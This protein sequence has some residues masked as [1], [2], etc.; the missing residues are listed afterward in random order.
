MILLTVPVGARAGDRYRPYAIG[1]GCGLCS[2]ST[3]TPGRWACGSSVRTSAGT[4]AVSSRGAARGDGP[5][6]SGRRL[7][8]FAASSDRGRSHP[9]SLRAGGDLALCCRGSG[10]RPAEP[11]TSSGKIVCSVCSTSTRPRS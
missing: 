11:W 2:L 5:R 9:A 1:G 8:P 4:C 6:T 7:A 10:V 3:W